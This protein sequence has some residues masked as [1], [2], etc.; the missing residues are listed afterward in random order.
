MHNYPKLTKKTPETLAN[1]IDT[2]KRHLSALNNL[3]DS[4]TSNTIIIELFLSEL[5]QDIIQ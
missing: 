5:N 3:G 4:V 1:L 2:I